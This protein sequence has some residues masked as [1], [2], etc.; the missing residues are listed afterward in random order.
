MKDKNY[1]ELYE[2]KYGG[3]VYKDAS[4]EIINIIN[5]SKEDITLISIGP[6]ETIA[7]ALQIDST[8]SKKT[9]YLIS[10]KLKIRFIGMHG[11]IYKG[12]NGLSKVCEEYNVKSSIKDAKLVF[13]AKWKSMII[14]P[15]DTCGI[16]TLEGSVS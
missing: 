5:S 8:I 11:S 12:Y 7:L 13:S 16:V 1:L 6:L 10:I 14:T 9:R 3:K 4:K 2:K 15:L